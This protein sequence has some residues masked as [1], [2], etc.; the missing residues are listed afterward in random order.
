MKSLMAS[1]LVALA[2]VLLC[3]TQGGDAF[4]RKTT[5]ARAVEQLANNGYQLRT[6]TSW[7]ESQRL[8]H[9]HPTDQ[10]TWF[11]RYTVNDTY[12]LPGGPVFLFLA[13]EAPMEFFE[14]QEISALEWAMEFNAMYISLEHR[15]YGESNPLPDLHTDSLKYLTSQQA[16]ADAAYFIEWF[17]S[18]M[19]TPTG[20]WVVFGC[21]Y[22][23]ALSAWFRLKYPQLVVASV[24][25][26][27]PVHAQVNFSTYIDQ[28]S[29]SA[30]PS[31]VNA[32]RQ[33]SEQISALLDLGSDGLT[34]LSAA[35][36]ACKV[37]EEDDVYNFLNDIINTVGGSDQMSNPPRY[38]LNETCN[39]LTSS[40]NYLANFAAAYQFNVENPLGASSGLYAPPPNCNDFSLKGFMDAMNNKTVGNLDRSW[41]WQTCIEFGWYQASYPPTSAFPP[42]AVEPQVEYCQQFFDLNGIQPDTNWTNTYYGGYNLQ[43]TNVLFT[44]G[45]LDPWHL[46]SITHDLPSGVQA[47]TYEAGHCGTMIRP[48]DLDPVSL[49]QARAAVSKFLFSV[50]V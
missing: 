28:F 6:P 12:W 42:L 13:G 31:C 30:A 47:V 10:R 48:S 40:D 18:T 11:Q 7:F 24:A 36:N 17:N 25:P 26:S 50:L 16:L 5:K 19:T 2:L 21:S 37:I 4:L 23:G 43:A 15:F 32:V 27:G 39:I 38:L 3:S 29:R 41:Y 49:T 22:S 9:F 20:S 44:N 46:M 14:F 34:Q 45:L 35:F 1:L 33:A 8:D